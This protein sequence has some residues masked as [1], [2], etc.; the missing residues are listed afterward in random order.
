MDVL[1]FAPAAASDRDA[2]WMV[3]RACAME[4]DC[5]WDDRYPNEDV[6]KADLDSRHLFTLTDQGAVIGSVSLF[7]SDDLEKHGFPFTPAER[8]LML[9]RLCV[10][11]ARQRQGVGLQLL[12]QAETQA[13]RDGAQAIH[14]LCDVLNAPGL[15]LFTSGHYRD[16]CRAALY[17]DHFAV[18][19]KILPPR[20]TL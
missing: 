2:V 12:R 6:L 19:E 14:C 7:P 1:R 9:T 17:G 5:C 11:P 8:V 4:A 18:F 10:H 16:V 13:T 3:W 15:A 20:E